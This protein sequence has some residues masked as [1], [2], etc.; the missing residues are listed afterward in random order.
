HPVH[1]RVLSVTDGAGSTRA[2]D[3]SD[4]FVDGASFLELKIGDHDGLTHYQHGAQTFQIVY[5]AD[6]VTKHFSDTGDDEF[7]WDVNGTG[8]AQPFGS[9]TAKVV[10]GDGLASALTGKTSCYQGPSGSTTPC[11]I[12]GTPA[13]GFTASAQNLGPGE[14]MT[15]AIGFATGTFA[16][17]PAPTLLDYVPLTAIIGV[18]GVLASLV[19]ALVFRFAIWRPRSGDPIIAQYEPPTG[20][21]AMLAANV[22]GATKRAMA[23]SI[24]DLAVR[25]KLR[26]LER[27]EGGWIK[28]EAY[29]VQRLDES[30]LLPD[31][32]LV[33]DALFDTSG[34][35]RWLRNKDVAL[36][37]AVR[38]IIK[39]V[40]AEALSTGIRRGRPHGILLLC[41]VLGL[42][43]L[44][45]LFL[46]TVLGGG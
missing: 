10:L 45:T 3:Q 41:A 9:V 14:N 27:Q 7:Y 1:L 19:L 37:Q 34:D 4:T 35:T 6:D 2:Y 28:S 16:A 30:G 11:P 5:A 32:Q 40:D 18:A 12:D 17:P 33:M 8:W 42:G 25:R 43:G 31:E 46:P 29:G 39:Q 22:V 38:R 23:A 20:I 21:S 36:G 24:V 15:V 44:A 26:M 13:D